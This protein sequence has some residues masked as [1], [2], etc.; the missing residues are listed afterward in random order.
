MGRLSLASLW[1]AGAI[2]TCVAPSDLRAECGDYVMVRHETSRGGNSTSP[3]RTRAPQSPMHPC[4]C[5]NPACMPQQAP[6]PAPVDVSESSV[7]DLWASQSEEVPED[8]RRPFL[9][10]DS[11]CRAPSH[12]VDDIFHPPR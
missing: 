9:A 6:L 8:D 12:L 11:V 2:L 5:Q 4:K 7:T 1:V 10:C 3:P